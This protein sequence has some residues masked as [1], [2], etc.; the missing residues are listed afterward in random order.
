MKAAMNVLTGISRTVLKDL[1]F[2]VLVLLYVYGPLT[3]V[4][5]FFPT[6]WSLPA[7]FIISGVV[8]NA[9]ESRISKPRVAPENKAIFISGCDS[10]FG[11]E[12]AKKMSKEG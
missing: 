3:Y 7:V 5:Y 2:V 1:I 6:L 4:A 8:W 12:L 11:L 10:G 9:I